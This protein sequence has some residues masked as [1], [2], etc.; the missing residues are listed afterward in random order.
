MTALNKVHHGTTPGTWGKKALKMCPTATGAGRKWVPGFS[1]QLGGSSGP[2][3]HLVPHPCRAPGPAAESLPALE[4]LAVEWER[5]K[6]DSEP[7]PEVV[8]LQVCLAQCV[9]GAGVPWSGGKLHSPQGASGRV[10]RMERRRWLLPATGC[11]RRRLPWSWCP[12]R[13]RP[14]SI[15]I[16]LTLDLLGEVCGQ[17]GSH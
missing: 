9:S 15:Y 12:C 11:G 1:F 8:K 5:R 7:E 10:V 2:L 17:L 4:D 16:A 6:A 13:T 14:Q 3:P